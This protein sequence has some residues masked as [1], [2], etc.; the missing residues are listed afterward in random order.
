MKHKR[1][2]L[3]AFKVGFALLGISSVVQ[4]IVVLTQRGV[5]NPVNFFS[6]FTILS[7]IFAAVILGVGAY[8]LY[9]RHTSNKF[10]VLR[11]AAALYMVVTGVVFS[12]LLSNLQNLTAVPWDNTVLHYIIPVVMLVDWFIDPPKMKFTFKHIGLWIVFP[13]LYVTYSLLRGSVVNWYPYPFLN[14]ANGGYGQVFLT[15]IFITIFVV[16]AAFLLVRIAAARAK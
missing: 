2:A 9:K 5:F 15:S 12:L 7:N 6:Y 4:E 10:N 13:L 1:S 3:I 16:S 8:Y 14:P 11:G